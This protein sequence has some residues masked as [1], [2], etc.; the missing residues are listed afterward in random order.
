MTTNMTFLRVQFRDLYSCYGSSYYLYIHIIQE[1]YCSK[2]N[3]LLLEKTTA[4][5]PG[6]RSKMGFYWCFLKVGCYQDVKKP[7]MHAGNL[8]SKK[9]TCQVPKMEKSFR[10]CRFSGLRIPGIP[11]PPTHGRTEGTFV[12]PFLGTVYPS[13]IGNTSS[14]TTIC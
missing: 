14:S 1:V 3:W 11:Y 8:G 9:K 4:S 6:C 13:V 5:R 10:S 2:N 7:R 12:P